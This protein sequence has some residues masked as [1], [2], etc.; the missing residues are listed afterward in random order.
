M[1]SEPHRHPAHL[2]D[3]EGGPNS[4]HF[5]I[6]MME[7][8][9]AQMRRVRWMV[10]A[11]AVAVCVLLVSGR[12]N[13]SEAAFTF[14]FLAATAMITGTVAARRMPLARDVRTTRASSRPS[15]EQLIQAWP[16]P[17]ILVDHRSIIRTINAPASELMEISKAGD[18]LSFRLRE[19]DVLAAVEAALNDGHSSTRTILQKVPA[20][21]MLRLHI[22]PFSYSGTSDAPYPTRLTDGKP[23]RFA[24]IVIEDDTAS[25]RSER[26]R[27]DFVANASHELRTPLASITGCIET[28]KGPAR[29]DAVAQERFLTIMSQQADRMTALID[30]LLS[31]N[32]IEMRGHRT[33]TDCVNL[34]A[35]AREA[36]DLAR[37]AADAAGV[38]L[39]LQVEASAATVRG[40][41]SELRQIA[42]NFLQNAI[43]YGA[44]G[45][46]VDVMLRDALEGG[47]RMVEL[48]VRD[49][50]PGIAADHLP[51][52]TERFYRAHEDSN[53]LA[54]GTGLGLAIVKHIVARHRGRLLIESQPGKGA[55]FSVR[56]P[57]MAG[58]A[59][60]PDGET[61]TQSEQSLKLSHD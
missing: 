28:L 3:D 1:V 34:E 49:Y 45:K 44:S 54:T 17:V 41:A 39:N 9:I 47:V 24:L 46:R 61:I 56:L 29:K 4:L 7:R 30:D 5:P 40:D 51:R 43:K 32:R 16:Q 53:P 13:L 15:Y 59:H 52:L 21:R 12:I 14:I 48:Q 23:A 19:P 26:M 38:V 55:I 8:F 10:L 60:K 6:S 25:Y 31:L 36:L 27:S 57:F 22:Q 42:T 18:P 37:P 58:S 50:G 35:T 2:P 11:I 33:P 20:E